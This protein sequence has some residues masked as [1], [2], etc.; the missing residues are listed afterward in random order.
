MEKQ[1]INIRTG[2]A[3][4]LMA[5]LW[6]AAP[7][8]SATTPVLGSAASFAVLGSSTVTNTGS[9]TIW[10]DLGLSPGTSI[11]GLGSITLTGAV[12]QTDPVAALAQAD[13][14]IA[15]TALAG[16]SPVST[17]PADLIGLTLVP[18]VYT[19]PAGTT[20]L[21]GTLTLDGQGNADAAWVFQMP[22]TLITSSGAVVNVINAGAGA[23][24]YWQV[25][26]SATLGTS[27][28]FAGNIIA[29]Q[30][31]TL[32]T[33]AKILCGRAIALNAAVT[34]DTNTLSMNNTEFDGGTGRSDFGSEGFSAGYGFT[35][36]GAL[37]PVDT[38]NGNGGVVPEPLTMA[39]VLFGLAGLG[40]YIRK[41]RQA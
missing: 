7:G 4:V 28:V 19:V 15:Y 27:T 11:T 9:T 38:G 31:I 16:L 29:D 25:G 41:R 24:V 37:V 22:S 35:D 18:G 23:G 21:S 36:T 13:A 26:S 32:N 6:M 12:H 3:L 10:G 17:L 30:S 34:M 20:N 2:T 33:T 8:Y 40:G 5:V 1:H 39:G 14:L